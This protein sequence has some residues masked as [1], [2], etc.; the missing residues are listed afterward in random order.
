MADLKAKRSGQTLTPEM[1]AALVTEPVSVGVK[2]S[3]PERLKGAATRRQHHPPGKA[4]GTS[5][6]VAIGHTS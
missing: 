3:C 5:T 6:N 1:I 4:P 2:T